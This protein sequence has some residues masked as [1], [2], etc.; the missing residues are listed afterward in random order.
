MTH[1]TVAS[2]DATVAA[3][4]A[5][6]SVAASPTHRVAAAGGDYRCAECGYG[7]TVRRDLP[8]CPM[9]GMAA[10]VEV[11]R[12]GR[13]PAAWFVATTRDHSHADE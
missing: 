10:W 4:S 3:E 5:S 7:V 13:Q 9:C 11:A 12:P 1:A 2:G 8:R 6:E